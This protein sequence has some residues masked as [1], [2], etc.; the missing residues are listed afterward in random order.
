[1]FTA[2]I[3]P[4]WGDHHV[5]RRT[6][7]NYH[8]HFEPMI[9][10]VKFDIR[11]IKCACIDSYNQLDH[12]WYPD[13]D[14]FWNKNRDIR[15]YNCAHIS[16]F[17]EYNDL[18]SWIFWTMVQINIGFKIIHKVIFDWMVQNIDTTIKYQ[19]IGKLDANDMNSYGYYII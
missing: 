11:I 6:M 7:T 12:R 8:Y 4:G 1:M 18:L 19:V 9:G 14:Y 2:N 5:S 13:I 16:F 10:I 15:E 3:D 17:G